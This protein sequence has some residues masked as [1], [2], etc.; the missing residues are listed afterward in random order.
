MAHDD[1][2]NDDMGKNGDMD[3]IEALGSSLLSVQQPARYSGG[4]V[5]CLAKPDASFRTVIAFP[6]LYEIG[7]S[8]NAVKILYNLINEIDD[9]SCD[10]VFAAAPDF[11]NL[12]R[13]KQLPLYGL[14]TSLPLNKADMLMFTIGFELSITTV[15]SMLDL[16]R[17]PINAS[18]R[19]EGCPIVIA[20]GPCVS[21]PLPF[22]KFIDVF[23]IGEAENEFFDLVAKLSG[24]KK[25]GKTKIEL[26]QTIKNHPSIW[27]GGKGASQK[28]LRNIFAGFSKNNT[29]YVYPVP[30]LKVTQHHGTV[31]IMRGCPNGCR[32]C[33]AGFWYRPMRQKNH[34]CVLDEIEQLVTKGGY[35]EISLSSLSSGDYDGIENLLDD[36]NTKYSGRNISFQLPSL[37]ISTF[38]LSLLQKISCVRFSGLTFA[39]E[40]P[41]DLWQMV[42]N[43]KI[44]TDMISE[45][46][47]E[48]KKQGWRQTKFYFMIG[49]PVNTNLVE[50][51]GDYVL[52][53]DG[54]KDFGEIASETG[55]QAGK[56]R[57]RTGKQKDEIG[58][59]GEKH[60][61]RPKRLEQLRKNGYANAR[62]LVEDVATNYTSIY[63]GKRS[64]IIV[65]KDGIKRDTTIYL[66]L[67]PSDNGAFYDVKS[68]L[69]SKK[70]Y[71][72]NKT[73][74]WAKPQNSVQT[75][76]EGRAPTNQ[77]ANATSRRVNF[78]SSDNSLS[79]GQSKKSSEADEIISFINALSAKTKLKFNINVGVFIPKP[80]TPFQWAAQMDCTKAHNSLRALKDALKKGG[81]KVSYHDPFVSML[82]GVIS[83]GDHRVGAMI[84]EA[85]NSGCRLD[86]WSEYFKKDVWEA[87]IEKN[88]TLV[89]EIL[90]ERK[91][92]T[93][94]P[95]ELIDIKVK[96][97]YL[98]CELE[99]ARCAKLT[100]GCRENCSNNCGACSKGVKL[101]K[102]EIIK[103]DGKHLDALS[104][105]TKDEHIERNAD[106]DT[107]RI[108]FAFEKKGRAVFLSHLSLIEVFAAAIQRSNIQAAWTQGFNPLV[109]IDFAAPLSLGIEACGE[110]AAIDLDSGYAKHDEFLGE[111]FIQALNKSLPQGIKITAAKKYFIP[112][113]TKKY[114]VMSL[115]YGSVY[116][117][118]GKEVI[119][120]FS[121]E[122]KFRESY[123]QN[124]NSLLGLKRKSMLAKTGNDSAPFAD[125]FSVYDSKYRAG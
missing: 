104:E 23:W 6:D 29:S 117:V 79:S 57:L 59:Y 27:Y 9:V 25:E 37:H 100:Q 16:G 31:E 17:I 83:R 8:N 84:D 103:K 55:L 122:K 118:D 33:Q 112:S 38:S 99:H 109:K 19:G 96:P 108:L 54:K 106:P 15:L 3:I 21:N 82:E 11:E 86:A 68:G 75:S 71:T 120:E 51:D 63:K 35:K 18:D 62:D 24:L 48:A 42:I 90:G 12:L 22:A 49:L 94:L 81:H 113:G 30:S 116:E 60:I 13:E 93:P 67:A 92:S 56:I 76:D 107:Y 46:L 43:K 28:T 34:D 26:L 32:F 111:H 66:A 70:A 47:F 110:I 20:G 14:E 5:G 87:I 36:I 114:S 64:G 65:T 45:I 77:R 40:T 121:L 44:T 73:L 91:T 102:N 39:V 58:D 123:L 85:F 80:H 52:T 4:E 115:F 10:R 50:H 97:D 41:R 95:W 78:G 74:L 69:I 61:E 125:F 1:T 98:K 88:K 124:S 72:K 101:C 119:S 2:E 105:E 7:M 89:G 53:R